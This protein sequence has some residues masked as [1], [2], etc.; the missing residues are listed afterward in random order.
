MLVGGLFRWRVASH[1]G[2]RLVVGE[3]PDLAVKASYYK[4]LFSRDPKLW[5][6]VEDLGLSHPIVRLVRRRYWGVSLFEG[7]K[8]GGG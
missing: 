5:R 6:M 8:L 3:M 2:L 1:G 4:H 7:R